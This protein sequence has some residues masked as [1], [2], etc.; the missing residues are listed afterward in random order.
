MLRCLV[1]GKVILAVTL[2][3]ILFFSVTASA[4]A[5]GDV[6]S[7]RVLAKG[8]KSSIMMLV[9]NSSKSTSSIHEFKITFS[10]DRPLAA[11]ARGWNVDRTSDSMTFTATRS[12]LG[13]GGRAIFII[14]VT[15]P[16]TAAFEWKA[17][18]NNGVELQ[19]GQVA[20]V[21]IR[22]Q[23]T[24]SILPNVTAP[25]V[26][27]SKVKASLG[28]QLTVTGRGYSASSA[29]IVYIDQTELARITTD[30]A[31]AFNTVVLIPSNIGVGLHL[32]KA[33]D[34][35]NKSSVIQILIEGAAGDLTPL[36]GGKLEVRTDRKE[37]STGEVVKITGSAVLE[38]PVS[39]QVRDPKSGIICGANP[40]VNTQTLLWDAT[41]VIPNN[42]I[43]GTYVVEA[44]QIV[45]KTTTTI[46]VKGTTTGGSGGT[47]GTGSGGV[48]GENAGP[49]VISTDKQTYK[50]GETVQITVT[51]ARPE[52]ILDIIIDGAGAHLDFERVTTDKAG[53]ATL[54]YP[55]ATAESGVWKIA[56]KQDKYVVR[57]TFTVEE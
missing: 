52:S 46:T 30:T 38:S 33:V 53:S 1:H 21:R 5:Q 14:K 39:L 26:N 41:C 49:L 57:G 17:S 7:A 13:P 35:K 32:I 54:T 44:K 4:L 37:Y 34:A 42:A 51:G 45:H 20:K 48:E 22:E 6:F 43:A 25:E 24:N 16:A 19:S 9:V 31:G 3:A 12:D 50:V 55:L 2:V 56:A 11:V 40:Q 23:P 15:D 29:V 18:D 28:E 10:A 47:G 8:K 27:I 36:Q